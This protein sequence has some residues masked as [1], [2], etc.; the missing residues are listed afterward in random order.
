LYR[1]SSQQIKGQLKSLPFR[2]IFLLAVGLRVLACMLYPLLFNAWEL[3][4]LAGESYL[5]A[6]VD[7]YVQ[8]ARTLITDGRFAYS[9]IAPPCHNRPPLTPLL[10]VVFGAWTTTHWYWVWFVGATLMQ[11]AA[12]VL[13][14]RICQLLKLQPLRTNVLLLAFAAHPFLL[15]AVRASTFL[16]PAVLVLLLWLYTWLRANKKNSVSAYLGVGGAAGLAALTHASLFPLGVLSALFA[17]RRP[18]QA[19]LVLF[20]FVLTIA[21]WSIRNAVVF[22]EFI[23][24]A[25]GAGIQYWKGEAYFNHQPNLEEKVY[26]AETG[27]PL[28]LLFFGTLTPAGDIPFQKAA[29]RDVRD[30]PSKYLWR[31]VRAAGVFWVP[32][33][34]R[35]LKPLLA[36]LLNLPLLLWLFWMLVFRAVWRDA[37]VLQL[38]L[39]IGL[40]WAVF[41]LLAGH[42]SYFVMVLP[43]LMVAIERAHNVGDLRHKRL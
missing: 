14:R 42:T 23:P 35:P 43:L 41:A 8:I 28:T 22:N 6:G 4:P 15:G 17:W 10:M 38:C 21:P 7:G 26:L 1:V 11:L 12:L 25:T 31:T 32:E 37:M 39:V 29:W 40:V 24:V 13:L 2:Q 30:Y 5:N 19:A 27:K 3:Q 16:S 9:P 20:A 34:T 36:S 33:E 18:K